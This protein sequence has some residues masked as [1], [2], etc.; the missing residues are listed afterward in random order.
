MSQ[1]L[2]HSRHLVIC[3]FLYYF[4]FDTYHNFSRLNAKANTE[5]SAARVVVDLI[6]DEVAGDLAAEVAEQV[7][8]EEQDQQERKII[9]F[10]LANK[11]RLLQRCFKVLYI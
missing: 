2:S 10:Q 5:L 6:S 9:E 1:T 8:Q 11:K 7:V 4:T 3:I